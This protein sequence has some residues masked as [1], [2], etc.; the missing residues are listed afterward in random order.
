M[1]VIYESGFREEVVAPCRFELQSHDPESRMIDHYTTGLCETFN[2][3]LILIAYG[4]DLL[5]MMCWMGKS[6]ILNQRRDFLTAE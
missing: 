6:P 5:K 2:N 4:L 1:I 3:E